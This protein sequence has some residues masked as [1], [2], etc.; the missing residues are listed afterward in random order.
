MLAATAE[1]A[2]PAARSSSSSSSSSEEEEEEREAA[3]LA[4]AQGARA[5]PRD[6]DAHVRKLMDA[7]ERNIGW[8]SGGG[9]SARVGRAGGAHGDGND[10]D[11]DGDEC[12]RCP[13]VAGSGGARAGGC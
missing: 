3:A 1:A 11:E 5:A 7:S 10:D 2:S 6:Y 12:C 9:V 8:S 13:A 4:L